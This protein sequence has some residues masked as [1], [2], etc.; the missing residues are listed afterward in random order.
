MEE[1]KDGS[2]Y[3]IACEEKS[4]GKIKVIKIDPSGSL[5]PSFN[6]TPSMDMAVVNGL[7]KSLGIKTLDDGSFI[8]GGAYE[9]NSSTGRDM[10]IQTIAYNGTPDAP[11]TFPNP[12][13]D[14][15]F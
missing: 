1:F 3:A 9:S 14:C 8:L 7:E 5:V 10:F 13:K 4:S 6:Y 2:G 12:G 15:S 11:K